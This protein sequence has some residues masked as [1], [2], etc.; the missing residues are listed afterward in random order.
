MSHILMLSPERLGEKMAGIGIR[1]W[2]LAKV[3]ANRHQVTLACPA[4]APDQAG[5]DSIKIVEYR[6]NIFTPFL[7]GQDVVF[8]QGH[9]S[10]DYFRQSTGIPTVVDLYDPFLVENLAYSL[11]KGDDIFKY[12]HRTLL[13]QL[14]L[15]DFFL[16]AHENQRLFYLGMLAA[17]GRMNPVFYREDPAF[18]NLIAMLPYGVP[19][20]EPVHKKSVL[21]GTVEGI[22]PDDRIIFFGG[23]YDWYDPLL[24]LEALRIVEKKE[25]KIRVIF[26]ANPNLDATPQDLYHR[27]MER[28]R[29]EGWIGRTVFFLDWIPYEIRDSFYM[30]SDLAVCTHKKGMETDLSYRTRLLDFLWAGIPLVVSREG[31]APER[32]VQEEAAL[33]VNTGDPEGLAAMI[34]KLLHERD[35]AA[36]LGNRGQAFVRARYT[37]ERVAGPLLS[38]CDNPR[39]AP[40]LASGFLAEESGAWKKRLKNRFNRLKKGA[41]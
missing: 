41:K 13:E 15:G 16:C 38:F 7:E 11:T 17:A 20:R 9:L 40:D 10:N 27:V 4:P 8:L 34:L 39:K 3:L 6:D 1:F 35:Y 36:N 26:I 21:R 32:L 18:S 37:W 28:C 23:I 14:R 33:G 5:P 2:E 25:Q 22:G 12:D 30:E 29:S 31:A 19:S 24:L